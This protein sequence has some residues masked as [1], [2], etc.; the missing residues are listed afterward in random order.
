MFRFT[1]TCFCTPCDESQVVGKRTLMRSV[2][3]N[4]FFFTFF[5]FF[6]S[7][8]YL[9]IQNVIL[10]LQLFM[11]VGP[12]NGSLRLCVLESHLGIVG[13]KGIF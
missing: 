13:L 11:T 10:R 3:G 9:S 5:F 2:V 8:M 4:R 7:R 1:E 12:L 6:K